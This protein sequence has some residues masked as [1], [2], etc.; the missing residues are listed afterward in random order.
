MS[1]QPRK[2]GKGIGGVAAGLVLASAAVMGFLHKWEEGPKRQLTVYAD[3]LAGGLPTV[4]M[5]LTRHITTTPIIVGETW[6]EEKCDREE[7]AAVTKVQ[8]QLLKCFKHTPPQPIF[9]MATSHAWNN[10]AP[11]TCNSGAMRAWNEEQWALGCRR[12]ARNDDDRP[13]WSYVKTG[14]KLPNGK[15]EYRFVQG[16]A[17]RREDEMQN[18]MVGVVP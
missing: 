1:S 18:C 11:A 17:N 15:P 5:G 9:D 4:C 2:P 6:A 10:G 3:K 13:A 8:K 7:R 16:L 12:L 14:R